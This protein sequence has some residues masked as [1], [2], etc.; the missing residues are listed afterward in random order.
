VTSRDPRPDA[1]PGSVRSWSDL[2]GPAPPPPPFSR[3]AAHLD[4]DVRRLPRVA[5]VLAVAASLASV[6]VVA[7]VAGSLDGGGRGAA[8]ER[9]AKALGEE[10][11]LLGTGVHLAPDGTLGATLPSELAWRDGSARVVLDAGTS[12]QAVADGLSLAR[13]GRVWLEV[14]PRAEGRAPFR[15]ETPEGTVRVVGTELEVDLRASLAVSVARG[16]VEVAGRRVEAGSTW[17]GG[18]LHATTSRPGSWFRTPAL[19][20]HVPGQAKTGEPVEISVELGNPGH[21]AIDLEA[22]TGAPTTLWLAWR[23]PDGA[24]HEVPAQSGA[25]PPAGGTL[26]LA[27]LERRR[28]PVGFLPPLASPG[29]YR[30]L[31][32]YR[33]RDGSPVRSGE[34]QVEVR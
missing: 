14:T 11:L 8:P 16:V 21:V 2:L 26:R 17:S 3:V 33:P 18:A 7:V 15:V 25:W 13:G 4:A 12:A 28:L 31:V 1:G 32:L 20:V 22:S 6:A 34:A 27:P 10:E 19:E 23:G 5:A 24:Q 29:S 9:V 30:V